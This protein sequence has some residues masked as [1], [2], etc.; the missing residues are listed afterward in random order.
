LPALDGGSLRNRLEAI[1]GLG[2]RFPGSAGEIACRDVLLDALERLDLHDPKLEPFP[3]LGYEPGVATCALVDDPVSLDIR[4][5]GLQFSAT[6]VAEGQAVFL[7]AGVPEDLETAERAGVSLEGRIAVVTTFLIPVVAPALIERG[8]AAIVNIGE[9]PDGLVGSFVATFYPAP[10]SAPWDAKVLAIPGVTIEAAAG[11][12]L[13]SVLSAKPTTLRVEHRA[14]YDEKTSWNVIGEIPGRASSGESV[15]IGAHYDTQLE[16]PGA[17][18]NA[19]GIAALLETAAALRSAQLERSVSFV[20]FG[21]EE[22]ASWGA[23]HFVAARA[24]TMDRTVGMVNLDALGLPALGRR[25]IVADPAM[26]PFAAETA[27]ICGWQAEAEMNAADLLL[28]DYAPF[29]DVGVPAAWIWRYPPQH[30]Y[31]HTAGD[32]LRHVD[33][34]HVHDIATVSAALTYRLASEPRLPFD[35]PAP[36]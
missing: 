6:G 17:A 25:T 13:L 12:R 10:L 7:G 30:P 14:N 3:Y 31:Y 29:L 2:N 35:R 11:R 4:A 16:G 8:V 9:A 32:T 22:F 34:G 23:A 28:A 26:A 21:V 15:V 19:S 36:R 33:H 1:A 24:G 20:A 18:D 5:A 27:A